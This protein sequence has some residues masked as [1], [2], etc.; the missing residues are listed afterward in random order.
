M[1]AGCHRNFIKVARI[2]KQPKKGWE[3]DTRTTKHSSRGQ[4][5]D[6]QPCTLA[7]IGSADPTATELTATL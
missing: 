1:E 6:T 4:Y 5:K 7:S 2:N 3:R